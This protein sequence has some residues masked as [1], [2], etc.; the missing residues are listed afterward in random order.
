MKFSLVTLYMEELEP[1]LAFYRD[2]LGMQELRRIDTP[3]GAIVFLGQG[4]NVELELIAGKQYA[5]SRYTG[6]S[7]GFDVDDM[8]AAI[9]KLE[10]QGIKKVSGPANAGGT[11]IL[12]FLEGP[13]GEQVELIQH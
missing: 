1:S 4:G 3:G 2:L 6:F 7:I 5:G 8:E 11:T 12:A 10:E 9:A 13:S